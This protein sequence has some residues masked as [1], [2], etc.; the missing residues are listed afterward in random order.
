MILLVQ[1]LGAI[2]EHVWPER[3]TRDGIVSADSRSPSP[4]AHGRQH[5]DEEHNVEERL[6]ADTLLQW[7]AVQEDAN[8]NRLRPGV[9]AL[10]YECRLYALLIVLIN[11]TIFITAIIVFLVDGSSI[12]D[13]KDPKWSVA[14]QTIGFCLLG[15]LAIEFVLTPFSR[16][17][18]SRA[19]KR[20]SLGR[21][22]NGGY[23]LG[24]ASS[25]QDS[26]SVLEL[27]DRKP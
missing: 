27:A 24:A 11:C 7:I 8:A 17:G 25:Q 15:T 21:K 23:L 18:Q 2:A 10:L 22:T 26:F 5:S 9:T 1:P 6:Q 4:S 16:L 19:G 20:G 13:F 3:R 14:A 12:G